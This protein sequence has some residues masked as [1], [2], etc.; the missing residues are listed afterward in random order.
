[1][2][3]KELPISF[4]ASGA[5]VELTSFE[6]HTFVTSGPDV[7]VFGG[8]EG[9]DRH[10]GARFRSDWAMRWKVQERPRHLPPVIRRHERDRARTWHG[11]SDLGGGCWVEPGD[12]ATGAKK[13]A[14]GATS[15]LSSISPTRRVS[16]SH[17]KAQ[18]TDNRVDQKVLEDAR[19]GPG[20]HRDRSRITSQERRAN[21]VRGTSQGP[22]PTLCRRRHTRRYVRLRT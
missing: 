10:T 13:I 22:D 1:M 4:R 9:R 3:V 8:L 7:V 14:V 17:L 19:S 16:G 12:V 15:S 6:A 2:D 21:P 18:S 5:H 20:R 11:S